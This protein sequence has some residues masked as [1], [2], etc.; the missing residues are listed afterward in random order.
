MRNGTIPALIYA[1]ARSIVSGGV[2]ANTVANIPDTMLRMF[3]NHVLLIVAVETRI[4]RR[5][6]GM[7][8]ATVP[9]RATVIEREGVVECGPFPRIRVVAIG[10]LTRKVVGRWRMAAL[11]VSQAIVAE[12]D[13]VPVAC[14][15]VAVAAASAVMVRRWRVAGAAI[16]IADA[17]VVEVRVVPVA[18]VLVAVA[19]ASTVMV[20]RRC[21]AST[22]VGVANRTVIK[23]CIAEVVR[24]RVAGATLAAVVIGGRRVT[25]AAVGVANRAMI[26]DRV[27]EVARV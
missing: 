27:A 12:V 23:D 11:A 19:A 26:K 20:R 8:G 15:L 17:A 21:V 5:R 10:A 1:P 3:I 25:G 22:T 14:V 4:R 7:A 13:I 9:A 2:T 18:R 16:R 24:V 6:T